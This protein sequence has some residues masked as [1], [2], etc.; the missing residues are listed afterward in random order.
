MKN[1]GFISRFIVFA[2]AI[3]F[4]SISCTGE[5][6]MPA[7]KSEFAYIPDGWKIKRE[8]G[9]SSLSWNPEFFIDKN[10]TNIVFLTED[11]SRIELSTGD[12]LGLIPG[13]IEVEFSPSVVDLMLGDVH[14]V[15]EKIE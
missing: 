8:G 3:A 11:G 7:E 15:F 4:L 2:V 5:L 1:T 10:G 13:D 14:L 12:E 6:L 9:Y